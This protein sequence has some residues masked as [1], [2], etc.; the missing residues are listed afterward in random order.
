M[1]RGRESDHGERAQMM[2]AE[3]R[4]EAAGERLIGEQRIEVHRRLGH[5]DALRRV[6]MVE[7]R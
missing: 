4:L 1:R 3:A 5:A 2:G 6:E 7:C